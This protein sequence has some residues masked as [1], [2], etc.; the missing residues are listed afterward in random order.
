MTSEKHP[1]TAATVIIGRKVRPGMEREYEKW[2]D[3]VNAAVAEYPGHLGVEVSPPTDVQPDWA[4]VYRFDSVAHLQAW[5]NGATRQ[6]LLDAGAE[7]FDGPATQ[8]VISGGAQPTDPLVTVVVTHR[9]HS[10]HVDDFLDWQRKMSEEESKFDGFRGTEIF[11][12]IEGLQDEWTTLYRY[13]NAEHLDAWLTSD[14]RQEV[15]AEGKKFEDFKMRTID[16]SFGSWFAFDENGKEAP[17]PS[18]TK[19]S[20]AVWVGL[21]PTVVL[22]TLALSPLKWPLWFG[23][24]VGNLLSS[25]IMSFLTMPHYVNRLLGRWL[26][27]RPDESP[28]KNNLIGIGTVTA[29]TVFWVVVFYLVTR[30]FWTL[31]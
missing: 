6:R 20:I 21:Y 10:D 9:V 29:L 28:V 15:L 4:V 30:Q 18:E 27:P 2:Q 16:D 17:P 7:Y 8:Q 22:L 5:M 14:K 3:R 12:P 23:L 31:P 11:R 1:E 24:L 25:F 19:T 13:D 26:W